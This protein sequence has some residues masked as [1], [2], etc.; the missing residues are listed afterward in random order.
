MPSPQVVLVDH[1]DSYTH[2]LA[3]LVA[4]VTGVLP[5]LVQHDEA[6]ADTLV[7]GCTHLV[8]SPGPGTAADLG[9]FAVGRQLLLQRDVPVLGVCL[10]MQGLALAYGGAVEPADPAHGRVSRIRHT[11]RGLFA[12][13]PQGFAAVRY[14]SLAVTSVPDVLEVTARSEDGTVMGLAHRRLPLSGVQ[15]H[16]ESVLSEHGHALVANWLDSAR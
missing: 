9:D 13:L 14:H 10:G 5:H 1:H 3:H 15:F 2:N 16:P 12:G 11:G 7:R 4:G 6:D 8:L